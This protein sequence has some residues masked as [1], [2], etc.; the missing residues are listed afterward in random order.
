MLCWLFGPWVLLIAFLA[1]FS[2]RVRNFLAPRF[3]RRLVLFVAVVLAF[4]GLAFWNAPS[5]RFPILSGPGVLTTPRYDGRP[6]AARP[7]RVAIPANPHLA[8][9]GRSP[10]HGD[11]GAS[12]TVPWS[13]PLGEQPTVTSTTYGARECA[14]V[15][16]LKS[17]QLAATCV[18]PTGERAVVIDPRNMRPTSWRELP[19][20]PS[21]GLNPFTSVCTGTGFFLDDKDRMVVATAARQLVRLLPGEGLKEDRSFDLTGQVS[22]SDCLIATLP[23]WA[24][25]LWFLSRNGV[26]G[27]VDPATGRTRSR[28]LGGKSLTTLTADDTGGVYALTDRA[29]FQLRASSV[30]VR[31][32]WRRGH[33]Q[34]SGTPPMVL[35]GGRIAFTDQADGRLRVV[36][37]DS[38]T[39][40]QICR[41]SVFESGSSATRTALVSVGDGVLVV[42]NSGYG[43]PWRTML[44]RTTSPGIARVDVSAGHCLTRWT[45]DLSSPTGTPRVSLANGLAYFLTK[46]HSWL[47]VDGWYVA[48]LE[49]ASGRLA[50]RVRLGVGPQFTPHRSAVYVAPDGSILVPTISGIVQVRDRAH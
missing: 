7:L 4:S 39:G 32:G 15:S 16:F 41:E 45:T 13:G 8:A 19:H 14:Q 30:G 38:R 46:E 37:L 47:G 42:N 43:G 1:L 50:Y 36:F 23:D 17:G 31:V 26:V 24:G 6:A 49:A 18:S 28:Q 3:R 34:G 27:F 48:A 20:R 35:P 44:G 29:L 12:N 40:S 33:G 11:A 2:E 21:G 25:R 9:P 5:G 22:A 10:A